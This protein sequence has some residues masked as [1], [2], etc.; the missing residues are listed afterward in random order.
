MANRSISRLIVIGLR[1]TGIWPGSSYEIVVRCIW[2]FITMFVQILQYRYIIKQINCG[3]NLTNVVD[4]LSTALPY[5]LLF[6]KLISFWINRRLFKNMLMKMSQDW[7]N[8]SKFNID[9]MINKAKLAYR[10]SK[11]IMSVYAIAVFTYAG[12]FLEITRQNQDDELNITSRQL[13][14]KMDFPFAYYESPLYEYVFVLQFF[15]LLSNASAI[16]TLDALIITL[17][18][19]VGGQIEMLHEALENIS[20]KNHKSLRNIVKPLINLHYQI[21]L[22][23]E[24]IE[25]LFSYIALMQL[26]CNTL[27]ICC[28]G[29]LIVVAFNSHMN[30]EELINISLFYIAIT[31]EAFIFSYAGEY[32]SNKSLSISTS[33]Y[34]SSWYLLDPRDRRI[35]ILLMIRSQRQL[36]IT[37][38]KFMD[39]S[40]EAFAKVSLIFVTNKCA[41]KD[42]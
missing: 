7:I 11:L 37:A 8:F 18:F 21:I 22:G 32:L 29:F 34:G 33:A 36:K 10:Y 38:G 19:H 20:V 1:L 40:M 5:S 2:I 35:M 25:N 31:L 12:V 6:F 26:L 16:A 3:G 41:F 4:G 9:A 28:I 39:L 15:Q 27:I 14:I 17:I 30:I 42:I 23:S 24:N 13:L